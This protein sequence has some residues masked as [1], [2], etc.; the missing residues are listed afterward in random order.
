MMVLA[1]GA[2]PVIAAAVLDGVSRGLFK[3][4]EEDVLLRIKS[5]P[6]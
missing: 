4:Q 2:F 3:S 6:D 5:M 1:P